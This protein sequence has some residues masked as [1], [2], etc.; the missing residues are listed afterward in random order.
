MAAY[1]GVRLI[2]GEFEIGDEGTGGGSGSSVS[3]LGV[4]P[5]SGWMSAA[6]VAAV[7][8]RD[9]PHRQPLAMAALREHRGTMY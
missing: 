9:L 6:R 1:V 5:A 8:G 4:L 2:V 7:D 3:A